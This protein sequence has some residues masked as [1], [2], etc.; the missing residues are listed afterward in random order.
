LLGKIRK[1]YALN[2]FRMF[3]HQNARPI[4]LFAK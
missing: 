3:A 2:R 4:R 1:N